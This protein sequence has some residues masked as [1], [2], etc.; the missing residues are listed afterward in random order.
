MGRDRLGGLLRR[1]GLLVGRRH[2]RTRTTNSLHNYRK[3]PNLAK[4]A[5]ADVPDRIWVSDITYVPVGAGFSYLSMVTDAC[6]R[7]IVGWHLSDDLTAKGCLRALEMAIAGSGGRRLEGL[8]HHSDR[9]CQYCCHAYTKLLRTNKIGISMTENGDPCE[10]A[11]AERMNRTIKEEMLQDRDRLDHRQAELAVAAAIGAY[12]GERPH[13][14]LDFLTPDE[15]HRGRIGGLRMRWKKRKPKIKE[16]TTTKPNAAIGGEKTGG[17]VPQ[18]KNFQQITV[19][20][21]QCNTEKKMCC[22]HFKRTAA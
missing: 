19:N 5:V 13:A 20:L 9:G 2:N 6:S 18:K 22:E 16:T 8:L 10:N 4:D 3:Y 21:F 1:H 14:S 12:N 15:V 7:K 11:L 17:G